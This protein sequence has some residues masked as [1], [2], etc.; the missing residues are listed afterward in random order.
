MAVAV[1][2]CQEMTLQPTTGHVWC[3]VWSLLLVSQLYLC[4]APH[5]LHGQRSACRRLPVAARFFYKAPG[6]I[7]CG[8]LVSLFQPDC[9][10]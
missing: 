8:R 1:D 9:G 5:I 2:R 4:A 6:G 3:A 10:W 7:R